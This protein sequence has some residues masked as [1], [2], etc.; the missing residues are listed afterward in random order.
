MEL[1]EDTELV[2]LVTGRWL[3]G[4]MEG[5]KTSITQ[6]VVHVLCF[7]QGAV[8]TKF[9]HNAI[10]IIFSGPNENDGWLVT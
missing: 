3:L 10:V 7:I 2:F 4:G 5:V 9:L 6:S 1:L 8:I